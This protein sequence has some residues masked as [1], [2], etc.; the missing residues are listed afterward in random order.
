MGD[1]IGS[2]GRPVSCGLQVPSEPGHYRTRTRP[3]WW[4]SRGRRFPFKIKKKFKIYDPVYEGVKEVV[5][6]NYP[7]RINDTT[8]EIKQQ[9]IMGNKT[10]SG[11]KKQLKSLNL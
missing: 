1:D 7:R 11:L 4:P 9:I 10:S 3:S 2:Q 5:A 8:T 6:R